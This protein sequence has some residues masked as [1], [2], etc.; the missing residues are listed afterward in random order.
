MSAPTAPAT[1]PTRPEAPA[2]A[3]LAGVDLFVTAIARAIQRHQAY[4]ADSPLCGEAVTSCLRALTGLTD[5]E[6]ISLRVQGG[7]LLADDEPV[8][9]SQLVAAD[10]ARR[11]RRSG[12]AAVTFERDV[13][14]RE[15]TR[16]CRE[17]LRRDDREAVLD[18]LADVLLQ[19]GVEH[20]HPAAAPRAEILELGV[21]SADRLPLVEH[22]RARQEDAVANGPVVHLYPPDK[23]WVRVDPAAALRD[24]SL[25]NLVLLVEDPAALATMLVQLS[26]DGTTANPADALADKVEEIRA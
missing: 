17:L 18:P 12:V 24:A 22:Q 25:L 9:T 14:A 13:T 5:R 10:L 16:F 4:P 15:I 8:Q 2:P 6:T 21:P 1:R 23:G 19:F 3:G 20:I 26:E 7:R 11:F